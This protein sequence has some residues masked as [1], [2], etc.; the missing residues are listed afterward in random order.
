MLSAAKLAT[1]F[2]GLVDSTSTAH[3]LKQSASDYSK[4]AVYSL[5]TMSLFQTIV[6]I[7]FWNELDKYYYRAHYGQERSMIPSDNLPRDAY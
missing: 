6:P 5:A 3:V 7:S 1:V 4:D 2:T